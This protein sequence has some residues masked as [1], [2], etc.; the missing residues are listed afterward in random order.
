M[1]STCSPFELAAVLETNGSAAFALDV[2]ADGNIVYSAVNT[3]YRAAPAGWP[4]PACPTATP[5]WCT[6]ATA[7]RTTSPPCVCRAPY[8]T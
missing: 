8:A 5:A 7:G 3:R 6:K 1:L 4:T 2:A